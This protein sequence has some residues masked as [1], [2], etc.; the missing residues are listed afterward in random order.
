MI[1]C[2]LEVQQ[3]R[4]KVAAG[5]SFSALIMLYSVMLIGVYITSSHQ[6]LSCTEWPLC[7]NGF[8]LPTEKHFFEHYHRVMVVI[9]ASLIY[10][11][12]AYAAKNAKPARKTAILAAIVVSVQIVLGMLV[13]NTRLEPL[14][15]A[16]H[17]STGI[18]LFAMTLMTFL[19]SYRLASKH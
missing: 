19:A 14:L 16:T 10:A 3:S 4:P 12:A 6:G 5:L 7:P 9:A 17:L 15:V 1:S 8:G 13:V 18:L 2:P 11:T